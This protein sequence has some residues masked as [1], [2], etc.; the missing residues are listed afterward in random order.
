MSLNRAEQINHDYILSHVEEKRY[1]VEKVTA[2]AMAERDVFL[3]VE[4]L[5]A[6]LWY[7]FCER[8]NVEAVFR[9]FM[10]Q[11]G[12]HRT[13]MK[14]LAEYFVRVWTTARPKKKKDAVSRA[15]DL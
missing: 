8:A 1:W 3:A 6:E 9:D 11:A 4:K 10:Q 12:S 14:N 5:D 13:S 2:F 7:Y 15:A